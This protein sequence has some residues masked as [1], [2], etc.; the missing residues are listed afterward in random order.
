MGQKRST[1]MERNNGSFFLGFKHGSLQHNLNPNSLMI[2]FRSIRC[3]LKMEWS[4][5]TID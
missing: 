4:L 3:M 5:K 2:G 1:M